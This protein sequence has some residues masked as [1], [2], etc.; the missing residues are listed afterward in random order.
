MLKVVLLLILV[1]IDIIDCMFLKMILLMWILRG[2][3]FVVYLSIIDI[4]LLSLF[5]ILLFCY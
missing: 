5:L 2:V 4:W 1:Y 3:I